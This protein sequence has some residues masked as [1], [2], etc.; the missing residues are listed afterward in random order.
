[1]RF[2]SSGAH[3]LTSARNRCLPIPFVKVLRLISE[4]ASQRALSAQAD[5][6]GRETRGGPRGRCQTAVWPQR[7]G[8]CDRNLGLDDRVKCPSEFPDDVLTRPTLTAK[9]KARCV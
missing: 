8:T 6:C 7:P 3:H 5:E 1:V 9:Q 2:N 4:R